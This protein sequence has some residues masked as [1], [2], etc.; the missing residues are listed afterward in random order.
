MADAAF[1]HQA[2][3]IFFGVGVPVVGNRFDHRRAD[4]HQVV[5]VVGLHGA[6]HVAGG[7][8]VVALELGGVVAANLRLEHDH[9]VSTGK[10]LFPIAALGQVGILRDDVG[11]HLLQDGEVGVVFV[12][13]H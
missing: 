9:H 7:I 6:K 10:L 8:N 3:L 4:V 13:H 1:Y 11:V 2:L 12:E 5:D